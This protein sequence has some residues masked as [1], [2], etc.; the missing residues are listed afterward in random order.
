[1]KQHLVAIGLLVLILGAIS[2]QEPQP[3][4]KPKETKPEIK[5]PTTQKIHKIVCDE[6]PN[7][8]IV[9]DEHGKWMATVRETTTIT[10]ANPDSPVMVTCVMYEGLIKPSQPLT[11]TWRLASE[12]SLSAAEFQQ[13]IDALQNDQEAV[14]KLI[15]K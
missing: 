14:K 1:M 5:A 3:P 4:P 11:K 2:A 8:I 12:K 10:T 15:A 13:L 9:V 7:R 6:N